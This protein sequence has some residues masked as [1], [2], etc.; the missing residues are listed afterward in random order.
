VD[1][2]FRWVERSHKKLTRPYTDT[3]RRIGNASAG[4]AELIEYLNPDKARPRGSCQGLIDPAHA[5][6]EGDGV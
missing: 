3:P 4:S 1:A 2:R 5:D 6:D